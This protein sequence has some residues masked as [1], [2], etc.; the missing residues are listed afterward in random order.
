[1][2]LPLTLMFNMILT[3]YSDPQTMP[4]GS[5]P[6]VDYSMLFI[7][8]GS[9]G[10]ILLTILLILMFRRLERLLA[11]DIYPIIDA[12][13]VEYNR[14]VARKQICEYLAL[15][16]KTLDT[17][18]YSYCGDDINLFDAKTVLISL[19]ERIDNYKNNE[20]NKDDII[21][22]DS[23]GKYVQLPR[24]RVKIPRWIHKIVKKECKKTRKNK[25]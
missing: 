20:R 21:W 22:M 17:G 24:R 25:L 2:I 5:G 11:T 13:N 14:K 3:D 16:E 4:A 6:Q 18:F 15:I 9:M 10:I 7:I 12:N 1:M 23:I 8:L 19:K